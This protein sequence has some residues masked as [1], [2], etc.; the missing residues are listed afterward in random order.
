[1]ASPLGSRAERLARVRSLRTVK[2]RR[3][4]RRFAFEGPTLLAEALACEFPIE[5]LY[6]TQAAYD[7]SP[8]VRELEAA[9]TPTFLVGDAAAAGI[10][11]VTTPSGVVAVAPVRL[12]GIE[13]LFRL[14]S[15]ILVLADVNDPANAGTLLRSADA[16]GCAG[17]V[18]GT[19]GVDPYHPKVVRGSMG[20]VLPASDGRWRRLAGR[21]QR[22]GRERAPAGPNGRWDPA[23]RGAL[24]ASIRSDRR[25][26][27][28]RI[29]C[30]AKPLRAHARCSHDGSDRESQ[31]RRR[32]LDCAVRSAP[33]RPLSRQPTGGK[34]SRLPR[35]K[36]SCYTQATRAA[37]EPTVRRRLQAHGNVQSLLEDIRPNGFDRCLPRVSQA[38]RRAES[39]LNVEDFGRAASLAPVFLE[40]PGNV[41]RT[42]RF[43]LEE[44]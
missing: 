4:A 35:V 22:G 14:G 25:Q 34:K 26:R 24:D 5:E 32:G 40:A 2:G 23:G 38:I 11:D 17:V 44:R 1:M 43:A 15:P 9:G 20:A 3:E 19:L 33:L 10:S 41:E 31:R 37:P 8:R 21:A 39:Q 7:A 29:G 36:V 42:G 12:L 28:P 6:A 27:T 13:E 18:F 16:F 30:V